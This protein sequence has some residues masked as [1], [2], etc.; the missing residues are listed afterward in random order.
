MDIVGKLHF[1]DVII[2]AVSEAGN[3]VTCC[4]VVHK[5]M[6]KQFREQK[7]SGLCHCELYVKEEK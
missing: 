2:T 6:C 4:R 1:G 7:H 3:L 5:C